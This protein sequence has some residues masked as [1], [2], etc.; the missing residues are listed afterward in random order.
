MKKFEGTVCGCMHE[1]DE[2]PEV[3]PICQVGKDQFVE[4]E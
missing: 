4:I 2:P 1:G 3:C